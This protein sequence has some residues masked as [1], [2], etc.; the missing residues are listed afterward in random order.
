M[1]MP[2]GYFWNLEGLKMSG[3]STMCS[4]PDLAG[5]GNLSG[6]ALLKPLLYA[7]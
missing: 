1:G 4:K 3:P 5:F 6:L 2:V 7:P